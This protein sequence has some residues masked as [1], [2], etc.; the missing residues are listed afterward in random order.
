MCAYMGMCGNR[1]A[2]VHLSS[3]KRKEGEIN[4]GGGE[5]RC[6]GVGGT[7]ITSRQ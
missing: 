7:T 5:G 1:A 6:K 2:C 3:V 4:L